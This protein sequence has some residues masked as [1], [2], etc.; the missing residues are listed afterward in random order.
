MKIFLLF[1]IGYFLVTGF[2]I[3]FGYFFL[4]VTGSWVWVGVALIAT[5]V[6]FGLF[7]YAINR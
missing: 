2:G 7:I 5:S 6:L 4:E 3:L 1:A